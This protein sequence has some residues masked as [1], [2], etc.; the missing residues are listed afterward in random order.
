MIDKKKIA[1]KREI[2]GSE[3]GKKKRMENITI[4]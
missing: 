1:K 3:S 2:L 4:N